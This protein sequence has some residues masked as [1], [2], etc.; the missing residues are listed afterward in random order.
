MTAL[1][2]DDEPLLLE[3]L[4]RC[5]KASSDIDDAM[6]FENEKDALIWSE[7]NNPDIAFFGYSAS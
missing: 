3:S 6:G 2:V 5:V 7:K 1:C 4:L